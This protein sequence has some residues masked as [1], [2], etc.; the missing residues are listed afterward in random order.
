MEFSMVTSLLESGCRVH[1]QTMEGKGSIC[2][3]RMR[4]K[5][6]SDRALAGAAVSGFAFGRRQV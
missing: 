2:G 1:M 4:G 3:S 6:M 5:R